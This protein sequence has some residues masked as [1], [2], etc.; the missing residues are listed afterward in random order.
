MNFNLS[1]DEIK[2]AI[3]KMDSSVLGSFTVDRINGVDTFISLY[4][5]TPLNHSTSCDYVV[6]KVHDSNE[7]ELYDVKYYV[8]MDAERCKTISDM[9]DGYNYV[10]INTKF[11]D[12]EHTAI[13]VHVVVYD[14]FEV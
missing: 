14:I 2:L 4:S 1:L 11:V 3:S 7:V 13:S 8:A 5:I 9:L 12:A 6:K 10:V